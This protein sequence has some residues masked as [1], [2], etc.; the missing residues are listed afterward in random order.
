MTKGTAFLSAFSPSVMSYQLLK[1]IFV[2]EARLRLLDRL[3]QDVWECATSPT[4]RHTLIVGARG[5]G[6]TH[7]V[8]L[9][10]HRI[11]SAEESVDIDKSVRIAWLKEEER[12][13]RSFGHLARRIL[14]RLA[15][16]YRDSDLKNETDALLNSPADFEERATQ[17]LTKW[18]KGYTLLLIVE[19]FNDL[20]T[21]IGEGGQRAFRAYLQNEGNALVLA[22]TPSLTEAMSDYESPFYGFFNVEALEELSLEDAALLLARVAEERKDG[23]L[24]AFLKTPQSRNR[25][26]VIEA[27]AGGH[28]RI[29]ILF[30]GVLTKDTLDELVPLF[31]KMLDDLTP[32][33]Q[34]RL[35]T[36]S[37]QQAQVVECL[38]EK[39]GAVA[40]SEIARYCL[41]DPPSVSILLRRLGEIGYLR[42]DRRGRGNYYELREPLMRLCLEVKE[43]RGKPIQLIVDFLRL[44]YDRNSLQ[45]RLNS[46]AMDSP[47]EREHIS[48]ALRQMPA[49]SDGGSRWYGEV[50]ALH[51]QNKYVEAIALCDRWIDE[52][53]EANAWLWQNRGYALDSLKR[54]AEALESYDKALEI[55]PEY[56]VAWTLMAISSI[57]TGEWSKGLTALEA[58]FACPSDS[59]SEVSWLNR[60][61]GMCR[62]LLE[63]SNEFAL[64]D[65]RIEALADLCGRHSVLP[66]FAMGMVESIPALFAPHISD[67]VAEAWNRAWQKAGRDEGREALE[68][69]LRLLDAAV[70]WREKRDDAV[71]LSLPAEERPILEELLAEA[72]G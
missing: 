34:S 39:R 53:E 68:I 20:L 69:P 24:S 51:L 9:L 43:S 3:V 71:L 18:L 60:G 2:Q 57:A 31:L 11:R 8:T 21:R 46:C 15:A 6:K 63:R 23:E 26:K 67:A 17:L 32:Y 54:Y 30:A 41:I 22:T 38:I 1:D 7:L 56:A 58:A 19:N 45:E 29:W 37:P 49:E 40:V 27:L 10:Y 65:E 5:M 36:L 50:R 59:I 61:R 12:G 13:V 44:W 47:Y 52:N 64:W 42:N 4:K 35:D 16:E 72:R 28:P 62:A 48:A 33:Y 25:L 55:D 14:E 70:R 66:D